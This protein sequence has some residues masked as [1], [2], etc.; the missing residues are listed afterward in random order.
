[1]NYR[2]EEIVRDALESII[3]KRVVVLVGQAAQVGSHVEEFIS[4]IGF[5]TRRLVI[6]TDSDLSISHKLAAIRD[7]LSGP[8][9]RISDA[10]AEIGPPADVVLYGGSA[11][12]IAKVC[13]YSVIGGRSARWEQAERKHVQAELTRFQPLLEQAYFGLSAEVECRSLIES[14]ADGR[15]VYV[16]GDT[17]NRIPMASTS[18]FHVPAG[19]S[20]RFIHRI[21]RSIED[22]CDGFRI[23]VANNGRHATY[24]G[25]TYAGLTRLIGP[26]GAI[27]EVCEHTGSVAALGIEGPLR[28]TSAAAGQA[29]AAVKETVDRL[30]RATGYRGAFCVD[31]VF[32]DS[33]FIAHEVNPRI[34][35]GFRWIDT[36]S[37]EVPGILLDL[38]IRERADQAV[39]V[40]QRLTTP[41]TDQLPAFEV[42]W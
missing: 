16:C 24:Y 29:E 27:V 39:D 42:L 38:T 25:Y 19:S 4:R 26:V 12:P 14:W 8:G 11:L 21:A 15:A 2:R 32:T 31:G 18:A 40:V 20:S 13:G 6:E 5:A 41:K 37:C 28:P 35:A 23:S 3:G 17:T 34:C 1:M 33:G 22:E 10:L 7:A 9:K 36:V 30:V